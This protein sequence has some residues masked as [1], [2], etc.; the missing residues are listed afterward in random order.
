VKALAVAAAVASVHAPAG[1]HVSTAVRNVPYPTN[2][3]F[4]PAG[5]MWLTSSPGGPAGTDGVWYTRKGSHTA[6]Q[7]IGDIHLDLGLR[8]IG[9][10]LYVSDAKDA[11]TGRVSQYSGFTG[12]RFRH[13]RTAIPHL[14]IGRHA[15][16]TIVPGPD[17]RIYVGVG[18]VSDNQG[19]PGRVVSFRP[20]G[21]GLR[22]EAT[23]LRNPYGLAF[24]PGTN[25][26]LVTDNGR[27]DLGLN[28]PPEELDS[29]DIA[30]GIADF[31]FPACYDQGGSACAG[32]DAPI[33]TFAP[34]ASS[35]G[36][37]I[38]RH[39]GKRGMTA[40]VAENGSS[41]S[42]HTG[43]DVRIVS[44]AAD[45]RSATQTL[46]ASGFQSHDPLGAAIGPDG[47]LYVTLF[48]S[49]KVLRFSQPR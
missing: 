43:S 29:F 5:G 49:G 42:N 25:R 27:D 28:R 37:A 30:A 1:V 41:F 11:S 46:F 35:D 17:G 6:R 32:K 36:L 33:A 21:A 22:L 45:G 10:S 23:G 7:V 9:G 20:G 13:A 48:M 39:W 8:W 3:A 31:G 14:K 18:S 40:F 26:L 16:D 44:V 4:D 47:A 38:T 2:I 24:V 15:V 12:T 34:H 19:T